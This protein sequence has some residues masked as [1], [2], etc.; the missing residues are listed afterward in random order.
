MSEFKIDQSQASIGVSFSKNIK[1]EQ[2]G[3]TINNYSPEQKQNLA[4]AA[5]E[6][7]KLLEQLAQNNPTETFRQQADVVEEA[8][9]IIESNPTLKQRVVSSIQAMGIEALKEAI[10]HPLANILCAGIEGFREPN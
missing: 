5:A 10:N 1:S 6:I 9:Q 2:I 4:E 7:Q 3:G 8:I